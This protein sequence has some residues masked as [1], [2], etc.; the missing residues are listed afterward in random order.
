MWE[1]LKIGL[2][3]LPFLLIGAALLW[4][5]SYMLFGLYI[6]GLLLLFFFVILTVRSYLGNFSY[7]YLMH[8]KHYISWFKEK[9]FTNIKYIEPGTNNPGVELA[10]IDK[11]GHINS[12][13]G[14]IIIMLRWN[15]WSSKR[16]KIE[17]ILSNGE[18]QFF[19]VAQSETSIKEQLESL[20]GELFP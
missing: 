6:G 4:W 11:D 14:H 15:S 9:G 19:P 20:Y 7:D 18:N 17:I 2:R 12:T 1:N 10:V 13:V 8:L 3:F 5:K 16:T